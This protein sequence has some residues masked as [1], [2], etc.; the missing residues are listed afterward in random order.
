[1]KY[2]YTKKFSVFNFKNKTTTTKIPKPTTEKDFVNSLYEQNW[3]SVEYRTAFGKQNATILI[4]LNSYGTR[5]NCDA[6][7][8][9][10]RINTNWEK[11]KTNKRRK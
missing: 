1:M 9:I 4:I 6:D 3:Q 2:F 11:K 7:K 8:G 10:T 5:Q